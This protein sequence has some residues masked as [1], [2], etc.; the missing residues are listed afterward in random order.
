MLNLG[1]VAAS[2]AVVKGKVTGYQDLLNP[3]WNEAKSPKAHGYTFREPSPTV[4]ASLRRLFPYPPREL[5]V[6]LLAAEQQGKMR[7]QEIRLGGGQTTP[8]TIVA[9]P[10]TELVLRNTDPF[11][12]RLYGVGLKTFSPADT[13]KGAERTWSV[14]GEGVYEIRDELVPSLRLWIVS[15]AKAAMIAYP[16][17]VGNFSFETETPGLYTV[18]VYF[19]G[20]PVGPAVPAAIAG[21]ASLVDLTRQPIKVASPKQPKTETK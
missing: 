2:A 16:D 17:A 4:S 11:A 21:P 5:C 9:T 18:Q 7:R 12:H 15:H 14:P 10:G 13:A 1:P 19:A 20:K 3:V 8:V 6:V